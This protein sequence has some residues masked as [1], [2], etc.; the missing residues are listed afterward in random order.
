MKIAALCLNVALGLASGE[1]LA[2]DATMERLR[3]CTAL[4][5]PA[6]ADC[7]DRVARE[8]TEASPPPSPSAE[9]P[10]RSGAEEGPDPAQAGARWLF[11]ETTSPLDY[12]PIALASA[13]APVQPA[14]GSLQLS[15]GCRGAKSEMVLRGPSP[16]MN[17]E[18]V[19]VSFVVPDRPPIAVPITSSGSSLAART[20][21]GRLLA[22]L[23]ARGTLVLQVTTRDGATQEA[24]FDLV[25]L[26]GVV[27][28]L[29]RPCRWPSV[30]AT[31]R[32]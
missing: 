2:Q 6:R 11:S 22:G 29:A 25:A 8:A 21:V 31:S 27:V 3:A 9:T 19:K 15:I 17:Q 24:R 10:G 7:L 4:P 32:D 12:S 30:D 20:D 18:G 5:Q 13:S 14:G 1:T 28:R 23:P 16:A 26:K